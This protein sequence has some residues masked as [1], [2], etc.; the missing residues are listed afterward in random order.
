MQAR[1]PAHLENASPAAE[2]HLT[3]SFCS[4]K[5]R[6]LNIPGE[7][8]MGT[9]HRVFAALSLFVVCGTVLTIAQGQQSG[10]TVTPT[11]IPA[12][13]VI[14]EVTVAAQVPYVWD[15]LTKTASL[16]AWDGAS[17]T[18]DLRTGG[19]WVIRY[20]DGG[21]GGGTVSTIVPEEKVEMSGLSP[22]QFPTARKTRTHIVIELKPTPDENS[23]IVRLT[24]VGFRTG[25]EWDK[26]YDYATKQ[27]A[28]LLK[29]LQQHFAAAAK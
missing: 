18:V 29:S 22:E 8:I 3:L 6:R 24:Q 23:T 9:S 10:V 16:Q 15:A 21:S 20:P 28:E 1:A 26:A 19:D 27:N 4:R 2:N 25:D 7:D 14:C 13:G 5:I 17:A 11:D 12:K